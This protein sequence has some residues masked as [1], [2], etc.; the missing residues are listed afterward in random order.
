MYNGK[1]GKRKSASARKS[2]ALL[3][4]AIVLAVGIVVGTIAW[5]VASTKP[6]TNTFTPGKVDI[7]VTE[8]FDGE[9]KKNVTVKNEGNVPAY[10]RAKIVVTWQDKA[11]NV[12][13]QALVED[14]D[15]ILTLGGSWKEGDDGY[16]Y[17]TSSVAGGAE[18]GV[19]I[20]KCEPV[21]GKA[22][23]DYNL[24]VEILAESIQAEGTDA[25]GKSA[26]EIAWGINPG[27]LH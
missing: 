14:T 5:L 8:E 12:Y 18:T 23:K 4:S 3:V 19:L 27:S 17:Y 26:A 1:H 13:G 16:Y 24:C 22:P 2:T 6:V 9:T 21:K 10:I 15:Y 11:G 20:E 7:T 25:D